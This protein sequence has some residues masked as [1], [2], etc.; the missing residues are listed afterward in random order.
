MNPF[1]VFMGV[2]L[3]AA[4]GFDAFLAAGIGLSG[5]LGG[6][7]IVVKFLQFIRLVHEFSAWPTVEGRVI[8]VGSR[9]DPRG[10]ATLFVDLSYEY[11]A[12]GVK[13]TSNRG[14]I[15]YD[16]S[17]AMRRADAEIL[18]AKCKPGAA[19]TVRYDPGDPSR[20]AI[21]APG[22]VSLMVALVGGVVFVL[23]GF[24]SLAVAVAITRVH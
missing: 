11:E 3:G 7:F 23:A 5:V 19:V 22:T 16:P 13:Y 10:N 15:V 14:N 8:S 6:G 21:S 4:K 18:L 17:Y 12:R 24:V 20:A 1:S 9:A 2:T